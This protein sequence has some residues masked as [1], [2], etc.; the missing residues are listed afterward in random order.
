M[1]H[2][3][4]VFI[5]SVIVSSIFVK[6]WI[7][8]MKSRRVGQY[9][10]EDGPKSHLGKSGIPTMGGVAFIFAIFILSLLF[11]DINSNVFFV[12]FSTVTFEMIGFYDDFKKFKHKQNEGLTVKGKFLAILLVSVTIYFMFLNDFSL[13]LP[14]TDYNIQNIF[15]SIIF[16][17]LLYSAVTNAS[18]FTD[19][20][21]GLLSSVSIVISFFFVLVSYF[22]GLEQLTLLNLIFFSVLIGYLFFNRYPAKVFMGDSGS[23]ALGAYI[24]A[25]SLVLDI[26]W[27]IPVFAVWCVIEVVSVIIQVAYFKKTG[28]KRFFKMAPYHHHLELCNKSENQIVIHASLVTLV[29]SI[30]SFLMIIYI[31]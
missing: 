14:L 1:L 10:R 8:F 29:C 30:C 12:L 24:V 16:I 31:R 17:S 6:A 11:L 7:I 18:N 27:Y 25:N 20:L 9:I 21:D 15:V 28:G 22:K 4:A 19:G 23:L 13:R 26:Y 5:C 2:Y 3:I